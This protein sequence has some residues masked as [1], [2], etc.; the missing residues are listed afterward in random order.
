MKDD[1]K[2]S[3]I[4]RRAA[5]PFVGV[6]AWLV[7]TAV[8][9]LRATGA[10]AA[11][12]P[13][14]AGHVAPSAK[15]PPPQE[16][17]GA[18]APEAGTK[19]PAP[20][21]NAVVVDHLEDSLKTPEAPS[22]PLPAELTASGNLLI[23]PVK[24]ATPDELRPWKTQVEG[25]LRL[26]QQTNHVAAE[27]ALV[28]I[29]N[30]ESP[31]EIQKECLRHLAQFAVEA[32]QF[33]RAQQV[34]SQLVSRFP[35]DPEVP[36]VLFRQGMLYRQM[37]AEV[38][39]LSKFYAVMSTAISVAETELPRY[40]TLV[41]LSQTEIADT[42]YLQGKFAEASEFFRKVLK[43]E[44]PE[45]NEPLIRY[46][47]IKSLASLGK[48]NEVIAESETFIAR[49]ANA[50]ELAEVRFLFSESLRKV[51]RTRD[52][53][54]QTLALLK[55]GQAAAAKD[56]ETWAYWQQR[57]GNDLANQLYREGDYASAL[58]V[59]DT[60]SQLQDSPAWQLP[61]WYQMGLVYERLGHVK[62]A[63]ETYQRILDRQKE[64]PKPSQALALVFEMAKWRSE[65]IAWANGA[66]RESKAAI[67]GIQ[68]TDS[69]NGVD[70]SDLS[71]I[72]R[73]K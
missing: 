44:H 58:Q 40:R 46:K 18:K 51:G 10:E 6:A 23:K 8:P 5:L 20:D 67:L 71:L 52:A 25:A 31:R 50:G 19:H 73:K 43:L 70:P 22:I 7:I 60:L 56:P 34:Y 62:K 47:L 4:P 38:M 36:E 26:K 57:T 3:G 35:A 1:P 42:Y 68:L 37:G 28:A 15:T 32:R 29:L 66:D 12:A 41:L 72:R 14:Q 45:I 24:P 63:A 65:N 64:V 55:A 49:C 27:N 2:T 59:Y 13:A 30:A 61:A 11:H 48:S 33:S 17:H 16:A 69:T 21:T 39:A 53:L 9:V 54:E